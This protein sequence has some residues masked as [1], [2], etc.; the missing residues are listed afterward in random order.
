LGWRIS[1]ICALRAC[2]VDLKATPVAPHGRVFKRSETDKEGM[3]GWVP[4]SA[5]VR[6]GIDRIRAVNPAVGEFPL[7]P[8]PR[9]TTEI[10]QGEIPKSWTRHHARKLLERAE[11]LAKLAKIDGGDF[12]PYRRA[13]A[14]SRKHLPDVDVAAAGGWS[15]TRALKTSYQQADD[16]SMYAVMAD[17]TKLRD[18]KL[19]GD[20]A[21]TA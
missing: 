15:D 7:F 3:S 4:L 12:H 19:G 16:A 20:T 1:A 8:A 5:S 18:A 11:G 21:E 10:P 6:E 2:D 13:W 14:S 17:L 9:A